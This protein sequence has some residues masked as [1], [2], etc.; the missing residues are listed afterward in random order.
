MADL[1][2]E[3]IRVS[4]VT[5]ENASLRYFARFRVEFREFPFELAYAR[6]DHYYREHN[7]VG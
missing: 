6:E 7:L 2:Q 5:S 4:F 1:Y 3:V